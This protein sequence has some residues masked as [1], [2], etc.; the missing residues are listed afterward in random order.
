MPDTSKIFD[1]TRGFAFKSGEQTGSKGL[2]RIHWKGILEGYTG[3]A[4]T[5]EL[6]GRA[7]TVRWALR[8]N[9]GQVR[10]RSLNYILCILITRIQNRTCGTRKRPNRGD[11][12]LANRFK[13][14]LWRMQVINCS[15][16]F[17][18]FDAGIRR[19]LCQILF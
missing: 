10:T 5:L 3:R 6:T 7:D 13:V 12:S 11:L 17:L 8:S 15:V 2:T 19:T 4:D 16:T 9:T 1:Q 14:E 18:Q